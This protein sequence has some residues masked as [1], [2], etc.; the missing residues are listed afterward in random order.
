MVHVAFFT[1][2]ITQVYSPPGKNITHLKRQSKEAGANIPELHT[3]RLQREAKNKHLH[4]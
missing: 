1:V 3:K 2:V 4:L